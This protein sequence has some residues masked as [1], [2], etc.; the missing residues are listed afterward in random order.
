MIAGPI[1]IPPVFFLGGHRRRSIMQ[2]IAG[3]VQQAVW[4]RPVVGT[5]LRLDFGNVSQ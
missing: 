1:D 4:V 2:R 3:P 5:R